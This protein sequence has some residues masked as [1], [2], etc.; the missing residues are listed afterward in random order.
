MMLSAGDATYAS[1]RVDLALDRPDLTLRVENLRT[2]QH[3]CFWEF[4]WVVDNYGPVSATLI[5]RHK[6]LAGQSDDGP[7]PDWERTDEMSLDVPAWGRARVPDR[8]RLRDPLPGC[9]FRADVAF[10]V[11]DARGLHSSIQHTFEAARP[12]DD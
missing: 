6:R 12:R 10:D 11:V 5:R 2:T 4:D 8:A 3:P 9:T 7:L 1:G